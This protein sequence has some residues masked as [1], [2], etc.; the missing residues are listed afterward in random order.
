MEGL[1]GQFNDFSYT[2]PVVNVTI[3]KTVALEYARTHAANGGP[4]FAL[5]L[6]L[7]FGIIMTLIWLYLLLSACCCCCIHTRTKKK[8][9]TTQG[10]PRISPRV[11]PRTPRSTAPLRS[12]GSGPSSSAERYDDE[13]PPMRQTVSLEREHR[14]Y[15]FSS[16]Y[17]SSVLFTICLG[18]CVAGVFVSQSRLDGT[19]CGL[20][21]GR[22]EGRERRWG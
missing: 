21:D 1:I 17:V 7:L 9:G 12:K 16:F 19:C 10:S 8:R 13:N 4:V 2:L 14:R 3:T 5:V 11:S 6:L 22:E 15:S 18:I 20:T